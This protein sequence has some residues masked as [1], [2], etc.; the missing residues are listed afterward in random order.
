MK[1]K[2][3]RLLT[4]LVMIVP[5]LLCLAL[6]G[7]NLTQATTY[8]SPKAAIINGDEPVTLIT[9]QMLP[10][11][12]QVIAALTDPD[13]E[14]NFEWSVVTSETGEKGLNDGTYD[15]IVEVPKDFSAKVAGVLQSTS[16]EPG[17]LTVRTNGVSALLPALSNDL[18]QAA[19]NDLGTS[20]T[21]QYLA[22]SLAAS[23]QIKDGFDQAADGAGQLADG[24][25]QAADGAGDLADGAGQLADG[26]LQLSSG[27]NQLADG[28]GQLAAGT[29]PLAQGA[30]QLADGL[31]Q[32]VDG[33]GQAANGAAP[34]VDGLGQYIDGVNQA[35]DGSVELSSGADQIADGIGQYVGGV[36]QL[37]DGI[38]QPQEGQPT[39]LVGG[40]HQIAD[41]LTMISGGIHKAID[42]L[43]TQI[44]AGLTGA[45]DSSALLSMGFG[46]LTS[47]IEKCGTGDQAACAEAA[48][49]TGATATALSALA[50]QLQE[51]ANLAEQNELDLSQLKF[52]TDSADQL[53]DGAQQLAGGLDTLAEQINANMLG[54]NADKLTGGARQ[55]ADGTAQLSDGL[56]QLKANG[57]LI[58]DGTDQ[59]MSGL[60]LLSSN[61]A[62]LAD[63]ANQLADGTNQ[64]AAG[65]GSAAQGARDLA[66]GAAQAADGTVQLADGAVQLAD[67]QRQLAEGS[68]TLANELA[69][70]AD[71]IPTYTEQEAADAAAALG[72]P[73]VVESTEPTVDTRSS[74][75]PSLM[76]LALWI[77]ALSAVIYLGSMRRDRVNAPLTPVRFTAKAMLPAL[78]I[79]L[80]QSILVLAGLALSKIHVAYPIGLVALVLFASATMVAIHYAL[81]AMFGMKTGAI[82]S[83]LLLGLQLISVDGLLPMNDSSPVITAL[84][85]VLPVPQAHEA[86]RAAVTGIG[87]ATM[88]VWVL[89]AWLLLALVVTVASVAKRRTINLAGLRRLAS[90]YIPSTARA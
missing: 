26:S 66:A 48:A 70:A 82:I 65:A 21:V 2:P 72:T 86:F 30:N 45:A 33:I 51:A 35:A 53:A 58:L 13:R 31:N 50:A 17:Q 20:F 77:G 9:G 89:V 24:I 90:Q 69:S 38:T 46:E 47:L 15:A 59:L 71:Q 40:A 55:L 23:S 16:T 39:S 54:E 78:G 1:T 8:G 19:V 4:I 83:L 43:S 85:D 25:G 27:T 12:R 61:G 56:G 67:G 57:A 79:G 75:S 6:L 41:V 29:T 14:T 68:A 52:V 64:L 18:V 28:I 34:L 87:S 32:Y 80:V 7:A 63:G 62:R 81:T 5:M 74:L 44:P 11:G 73:V 3:N 22:T 84:H 76:A 60:G 37:Y 88:P 36:Q 49:G 10:A 42:G